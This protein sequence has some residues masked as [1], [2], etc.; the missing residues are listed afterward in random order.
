[1]KELVS[2]FF[3]ASVL[4]V[5]VQSAGAEEPLGCRAAGPGASFCAGQRFARLDKGGTRGLSY[6][7]DAKGYMSKVVVQSGPEGP[8]NQAMIES[9][10]MEM[11]SRQANDIGRDFEFSD[12]TSATAGGAPFGTLSYTLGGT[13][14]DQP[15]L[16]SYVAVKGVIVQVIS[17]IAL[18]GTKRDAKALML[19][20]HR[21]LDAIQL[22]N[23]DPAT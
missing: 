10:I 6:W 2:A 20:H 17:Q 19:A 14:Q 16:H 23:S 18:K 3:L 21:A 15:I 1:M 5:P 11:V 8:A 13:G 12:L 22:T 4:M 7:I 9:Q